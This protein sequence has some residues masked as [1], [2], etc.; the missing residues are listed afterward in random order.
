MGL[1]GARTWPAPWACCP[2]FAVNAFSST[3][4]RSRQSRAFH[5]S[6]VPCSCCRCSSS[7][8]RGTYGPVRENR[9]KWEGASCPV[10]TR[11]ASQAQSG[12]A[13]TL[14]RERTPFRRLTPGFRR[15]T[16]AQ[17]SLPRGFQPLSCLAQQ[18]C[19]R[20]G[21]TA[22][23]TSNYSPRATRTTRALRALRRG[24]VLGMVLQ[25]VVALPRRPTAV[26][27]GQRTRDAR[28]G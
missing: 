28:A 13:S 10:P 14:V 12:R 16:L 1:A 21:L 22:R 11:H 15:Q 6:P 20:G 9:G 19:G 26:V 2:A 5:S 27:R 25:M 3:F 23:S 18:M 4:R 17:P 7:L 24:M 8:R